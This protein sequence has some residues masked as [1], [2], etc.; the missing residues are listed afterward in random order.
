MGGTAFAAEFAR[1]GILSR[2]V[3]LERAIAQ[4][5]NNG[6]TYERALML[7]DAAYEKAGRGQNLN[8]RDT[9]Q[10]SYSPPGRPEDAPGQSIT[11][12]KTFD[13]VPG[14]SPLPA[15]EDDAG[16]IQI[17]EKANRRIPA[18]SETS[19]PA[20]HSESA[21]QALRT[22]PAGAGKAGP[23]QHQRAEKALP[24]VPAPAHPSPAA[25]A[26]A[27]AAR[28]AAAQTVLDS[29]TVRD[30]R[31]IGDVRWGELERLRGANAREA[32]VIRQILRHTNPVDHSVKVRDAIGADDLARFIQRA[33]E[34]DDLL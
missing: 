21:E 8:S 25:I 3:A 6:G 14:A 26:A 29:F 15:R 19:A 4:F 5:Q 13:R 17:A 18:S 30:G 31:P 22:V 23:G 28:R 11:V 27:A 9:G 2:D 10:S 33:A 34:H 7:L 32:A 16:Q 24:A 20:G 12:E 1:Y